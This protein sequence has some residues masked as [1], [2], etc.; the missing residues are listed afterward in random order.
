MP[1]SW[2]I[3]DFE[4]KTNDIKKDHDIILCFI[5][6]KSTETS[7]RNDALNT[8]STSDHIVAKYHY[9]SRITISPMFFALKMPL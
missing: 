5:N 8:K 3:E 1:L 4:K 9:S 2:Y 7:T 6:E